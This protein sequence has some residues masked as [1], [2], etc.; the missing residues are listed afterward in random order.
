MVGL[1]PG[2]HYDLHVRS[3]TNFATL[4]S[5]VEP[6]D[7]GSDATMTLIVMSA[8]MYQLLKGEMGSVPEDVAGA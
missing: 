5:N 8:I 1:L 4:A 2:R 6:L 3:P 7:R